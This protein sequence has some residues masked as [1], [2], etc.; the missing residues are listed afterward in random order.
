MWFKLMAVVWIFMELVHRPP[1]RPTRP[2]TRSPCTSPL[3]TLTSRR[4][5]PGRLWPVCWRRCCQGGKGSFVVNWS[6]FA[7]QRDSAPLQQLANMAKWLDHFHVRLRYRYAWPGHNMDLA[8]VFQ[9]VMN[10]SVSQQWPLPVCWALAILYSYLQTH[11]NEAGYNPICRRLIEHNPDGRLWD[12][13]DFLLSHP[14]SLGLYR[15]TFGGFLFY[16]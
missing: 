2:P 16:A 15:R 11:L 6:N 14:R 7:Y 8:R 9:D 10:F 5:Y 1:T 3:R 13:L 4:H 12:M